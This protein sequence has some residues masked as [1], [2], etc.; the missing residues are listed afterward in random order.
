MFLGFANIWDYS[1]VV[2][3]D[4]IESWPI[5]DTVKNDPVSHNRFPGFQR[6]KQI[7]NEERFDVELL[8]L[9]EGDFSKLDSF[10]DEDIVDLYRLSAIKLA[11]MYRPTE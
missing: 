5:F 8:A 2:I 10:L 1:W 11:A 3:S 4:V 6:S 7:P 9:A